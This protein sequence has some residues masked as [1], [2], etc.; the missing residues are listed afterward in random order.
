MRAVKALADGASLEY[1]SPKDTSPPKARN[2]APMTMHTMTAAL[3]AWEHA[4]RVN[5]DALAT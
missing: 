2:A 3:P 1:T 4:D 5:E